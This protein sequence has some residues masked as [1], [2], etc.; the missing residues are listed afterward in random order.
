MAHTV[1]FTL[2]TP[3][4]PPK[5]LMSSYALPA[6][7]LG[8]KAPPTRGV[9]VRKVM[10]GGRAS[11]AGW[12]P[13]LD[14]HEDTVASAFPTH[15]GARPAVSVQEVAGSEQCQDLQ[16]LSQT[17]NG[18]NIRKRRS[19]G[20]A[21][22][23]AHVM[24]EPENTTNLAA[25]QPVVMAETLTN[26]SEVVKKARRRTIYI[27]SEDTSILT[28]HPGASLR[29]QLRRPRGARRSDIFLD[30]AVLSEEENGTPVRASPVPRNATQV[31]KGLG[32][33]PKR[34]PLARSMRSSQMNGVT[35]DV[36]GMGGGKEN[37]PPGFMAG[38]AKKEKDMLKPQD[39]TDR[40]RKSPLVSKARMMTS[41]R[42]IT[43]TEASPRQERLN[44]MA[45]GTGRSSRCE[46]ATSQSKTMIPDLGILDLDVIEVSDSSVLHLDESRHTSRLSPRQDPRPSLNLATSSRLRPHSSLL[47]RYPVL[48]DNISIPS[49]YNADHLASQEITLSHLI[50]SILD[51]A[52]A[53]V[54]LSHSPGALRKEFMTLH[55]DEASVVL[56]QR[57]Q[58]SLRFGAL[59]I[60]RDGLARVS[61]IK[62]DL[63]ARQA[64][65]DLWTKTYNLDML[66]AA[67]E[68]VIG[69][70][71][72]RGPTA[73]MSSRASPSC[74]DG[75]NLP[76][77]TK[78]VQSFLLL[79]LLR[80]E[81][82]P[83]RISSPASSRLSK[84]P[85]DDEITS[86]SYLWRRTVT[87]SLLL[88]RLL[89]YFASSF[90]TQ[91]GSACLF[92]HA[93]AHKT[94]M[95]MLQAVAAMLLPSIG[96]VKR[97]VGHLDYNLTH[98]QFALQEYDYRICNIAVDL[99]DGVVLTRLVEHVFFTFSAAADT[100]ID[101]TTTI[102][103]FDTTTLVL[104]SHPST[105]NTTTS[106]YP[107]STHL[108]HPTP[109]RTHK[110]HNARLVLAA[111][112]AVSPTHPA[113]Q[114]ALRDL[115]P[116]D[117]VNGHREKT[118]RLLWGIVLGC[119]GLGSVLGKEGE[120]RLEREVRRLKGE[121]AMRKHGCV[122]PEGRGEEEMREMA[123]LEKML[124]EWARL[125]TL[126][127][128][129][130]AGRSATTPASVSV[131][132]M[133]NGTAFAAIARTYTDSP[134]LIALAHKQGWDTKLAGLLDG[135]NVEILGKE[136][137]LGLLA[138]LATA[139]L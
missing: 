115:E 40:S 106:P 47:E 9:R 78:S 88:I 125:V 2:P 139:V 93:S 83:K 120:R 92:Q 35:R 109:T 41:P 12:D 26:T 58:A 28:I 126:L 118:L 124:M 33:P 7:Q 11:L 57:L 97:I 121:L 129:S 75:K 53:G 138:L 49:L 62:D 132:T 29:E 94:S 130:T 14:I 8:L 131:S 81:D 3:C 69:R 112:L 86:P 79:F 110:L 32:A 16:E 18:A 67:A 10:R 60:S 114:A 5:Y 6:A 134:S 65:L 76:K 119:G 116:M 31:S 84:A 44:I 95:S 59:S 27:P 135:N 30:L 107:L 103:D 20:A 50:N 105:A 113:L 48:C 91:L 17:P 96:D 43:M 100:G 24:G 13:T 52:N 101:D 51:R 136:V 133:P 63:A 34:V 73:S 25:I 66:Q 128:S 56:Q 108:H 1:D 80:N 82:V 39:W 137:V 90:A 22:R 36:V 68:V 99:R 89:D 4:P 85:N 77:R 122:G 19:L 117:L 87:R 21:H 127:D 123:G 74:G 38:S 61:R 104:P 23:P 111:L 64:F 54:G 71:I 72:A 45:V 37:L 102:R 15:A 42:S 98:T 55:N 70:E 46:A